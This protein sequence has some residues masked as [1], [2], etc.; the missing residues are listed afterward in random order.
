[1]SD[2]EGRSNCRIACLPHYGMLRRMHPD[3]PVMVAM[4]AYDLYHV[5]ANDGSFSNSYPT[6]CCKWNAKSEG[7]MDYLESRHPENQGERK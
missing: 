3:V 6:T 4:K 7:I 5:E 1:M 2:W